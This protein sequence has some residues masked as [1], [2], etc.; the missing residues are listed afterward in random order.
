MFLSILNIW[1]EALRPKVARTTPHGTL[2]PERFTLSEVI[3]STIPQMA[4][5]GTALS[6]CGRPRVLEQL[7]RDA[8]ADRILLDGRWRS[9]RLCDSGHRPSPA[10]RRAALLSSPIGMGRA[11]RSGLLADHRP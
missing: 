9:H 8:A 11:A 1:A 4:C 10:D 7:L 5:T 3:P 6:R 2:A